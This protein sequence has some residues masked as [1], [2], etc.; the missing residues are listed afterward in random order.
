MSKQTAEQLYKQL[1]FTKADIDY[2]VKRLK[3]ETG[4]LEDLSEKIELITSEYEANY[5]ER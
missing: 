4:Y 3:T 1:C 5:E 2:M